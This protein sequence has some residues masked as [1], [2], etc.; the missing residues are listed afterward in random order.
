MRINAIA[1]GVAD[2]I[3]QAADSIRLRG[4]GHLA[5]RRTLRRA[6]LF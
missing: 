3:I 2:C 1:K 4:E 6:H 5:E